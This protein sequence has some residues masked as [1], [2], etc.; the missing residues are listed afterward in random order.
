MRPS[1]S[2]H[3]Q[4]GTCRCSRYDTAL[5]DLDTPPERLPDPPDWQ[6]EQALAGCSCPV[7]F[8][9]TTTDYQV[10]HYFDCPE[11]LR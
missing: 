10:V 6:V 3:K 4:C 9:P 8:N 11:A 5:T 7:V 2:V 1:E